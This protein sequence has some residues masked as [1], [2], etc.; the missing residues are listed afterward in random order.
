M[1]ALKGWPLTISQQ[2][3]CVGQE[4]I[5]R[6]PAVP[7]DDRETAFLNA[8]DDTHGALFYAPSRARQQCVSVPN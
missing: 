5:R 4:L 1:S 6:H 3:S 8:V 7:Q 2:P